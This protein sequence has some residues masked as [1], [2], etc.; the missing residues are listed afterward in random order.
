M[1][2]WC[3]A[4][5]LSASLLFCH[6][7][8]SQAQIA[9]P[10][11]AQF[12]MQLD[13]QAIQK[14]SIGKMLIAAGKEAAVKEFGKLEGGDSDPMVKV[15]EILGMDPLKEVQ[16]VVVTATDFE[17]PETSMTLWLH[18][19]K[20]TGNIEG[21]LLGLPNY[22][23]ESYGS[24]QIHSAQPEDARIYGAIHRDKNK[25]H[26]VVISPNRDTLEHQ[27][28]LLDDRKSTRDGFKV[29]EL[30]SK[31]STLFS[32]QVLKFPL[33]EMGEGPHTNVAKRLKSLALAIDGSDD[34]IDL[35]LDL[36][37]E[38][39]KQAEQIRQMVQGLIAMVEFAQSMDVDDEELR[40]AVQYFKGA[41][42]TVDGSTVK[43]QMRLP[44]D[45]IEAAIR[46]QLD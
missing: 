20:T 36:E 40:K 21:L 23:V 31:S 9:V 4:W 5:L 2:R 19:G 15:Q 18:L 35:R 6:S 39:D 1:F 16:R 33:E 10:D 46:E 34:D 27:L 32:V 29:L 13:L 22:E 24:H 12:V 30:P 25:N 26:M 11:D 7:S 41:K 45:A 3:T 8:V 44:A 43:L 28:D 14:T 37:T 17:H 42:S 38:T